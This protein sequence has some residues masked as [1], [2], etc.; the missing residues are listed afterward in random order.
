MEDNAFR[1]LISHSLHGSELLPVPLLFRD[2]AFDA[3]GK[4]R[5]LGNSMFERNR[6]ASVSP[7]FV[8]DVYDLLKVI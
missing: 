5:G 2:L 3:K 1:L 8:V 4:R 7:D 6:Y